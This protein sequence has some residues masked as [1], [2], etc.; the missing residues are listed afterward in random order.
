MAAWIAERVLP[1]LTK[2]PSDGDDDDEEERDLERS[3]P[4][5]AQITE[6]SSTLTSKNIHLIKLVCFH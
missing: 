5:A 6:V 4:L 1:F 2:H 3:Q